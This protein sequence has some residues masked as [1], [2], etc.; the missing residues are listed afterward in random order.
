[1]P[2]IKKPMSPTAHVLKGALVTYLHDRIATDQ[3]MPA[4]NPLVKDVTSQNFGGMRSRV[5]ARVRQ[6][7]RGKLAQDADLGDLMDL[8]D[9]FEEHEGGEEEMD[10]DSVENEHEVTE[11][12]FE[13]ETEEH[14]EEADDAVINEVEPYEH[15][16]MDEAYDRRADDARHHL[17][18]DE[19]PEEME[20]REEGEDRKA[21]EDRRHRAEDEMECHDRRRRAEDSRKRRAARDKKR[22]EDA[23]RRLG[24][25]ETEEEAQDRRARDRAMDK[26]RAEDIHRMHGDKMRRAADARRR[27][28][29]KRRAEDEPPPFEG[30]PE[31]GGTMTKDAMNQEIKRQI[32]L[33]QDNMNN[34]R[35]AEMFVRP[36][37]GEI[38]PDVVMGLDSATKVYKHALDVLE[39]SYDKS[40]P[41]SAMKAV[42]AAQPR[43]SARPHV[44]PASLGMDST[45]TSGKSFHDRFP[46]AARIRTEA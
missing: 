21:A 4:L 18:R 34:A 22:A 9:A 44:V 40:W 17:G 41:E 30:R 45:A 39:V 7:C 16:L 12:P 26:K 35:V 38:A 5:A 6:A 14:E 23:R 11:T 1:M 28:E 32:K 42:I 25:D 27:A 10:A 31:V 2:G 3:A 8:L 13:G 20:E 37:I 29:D 15:A 24:R 46:G 36:W 33:A 43:P 19:T